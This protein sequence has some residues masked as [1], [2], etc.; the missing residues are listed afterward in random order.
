VRLSLLLAGWR[1]DPKSLW[2]A[3]APFGTQQQALRNLETAYG[4]QASGLAQN[5]KFKKR[6]ATDAAEQYWVGSG[7]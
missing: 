7:M 6:C 4:R 2:L 1:R 3:E 5:P